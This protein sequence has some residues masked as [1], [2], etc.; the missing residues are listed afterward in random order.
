VHNFDKTGFQIGVI[1]SMEVVTGAERRTRPDLVQPGDREW[2]T[3]IQSI[4]AAGYATP[5]FYKG[6][7]HISAWYEEASIPRDWKLS[8]SENG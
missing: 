3:V 4:C 6:R 1:G 7:V 2:V 5:S 8:V